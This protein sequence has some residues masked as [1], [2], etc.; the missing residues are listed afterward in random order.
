MTERLSFGE[1][2]SVPLL[3]PGVQVEKKQ[4]FCW[5]AVRSL[6]SHKAI[7]LLLLWE[8]VTGLMY[9]LIMKPSAYLHNLNN[10]A[11]VFVA[12]IVA[13]LFLVLTPLAS[14][15][16]DVKFSRF[17]TFI[18]STY[19]MIVSSSFTLLSVVIIAFAV[20]DFSYFSYTVFGFFL[21]STLAYLCGRIVFLAN[22]LQF[23]TDQLRDAPTYCSVLFLYSYYWWDNFSS[24]LTLSINIPGHEIIINKHYDTIVFDKLKA[25]L[26][27]VVIFTSIFLS[28]TVILILHKKKHWLFTEGIGGNPY[29][30]TW[31]V[32]KFAIQH[33]K[34]LRRSAFTF[35]ENSFPSRLDFGKQRYGGPFTTEQVEDVKVLFNMV[36]VF[37]SLG[38]VFFLDLCATVALTQHH[39]HHD[40]TDFSVNNPWKVFFLHNG[41]LSP[42]LTLIWIPLLFK[43][44]LSNWLPNMF[45]RI[46][47][48]IIL[49]S[50]VFALYLIQDVIGCGS[51]KNLAA[52]CYNATD[53]FIHTPSFTQFTATCVVVLQ[54]IMS[55]IYLTLLYISVWELIC[56]QS[57]QFMKGLLFGLFYTIR[58]FYQFL[59]AATIVSLYYFWKSQ[60]VSSNFILFII[61]L[62]LG[63]FFFIVF[64]VVTRKYQYRKR[65][66][67]C[68]IYQYAVDY[69][70][71]KG[72]NN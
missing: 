20:S 19:C 9:N 8:F 62:S 32:V 24:L 52:I 22:V 63:F 37:L 56:C 5:N 31:G 46:G 18:W 35:C 47:L 54:N 4:W 1:Y 69:Y 44:Y 49:L 40:K 68:N 57:P 2:S 60:F 51:Q 15:V 42:L 23:G 55:S 64:V 45:K 25:S 41:I 10:K 16:A 38:P 30:L 58:A 53:S 13:V 61:N 43:L 21:I 50:A 72:G 26:Y 48:S 27:V 59:A 28:V 67:I 33:K 39:Q 11:A 29:K 66:D 7:L 6:G 14:F 65:D 36:K 71:S 12:C 17:K 34:P 70:S 3:S